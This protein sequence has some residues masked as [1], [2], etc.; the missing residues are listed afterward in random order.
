MNPETGAKTVG[1][2]IEGDSTQKFSA[3][4]GGDAVM[5]LK[6]KDSSMIPDKSY[7][8]LVRS[9]IRAVIVNNDPVSDKVL[10]NHRAGYSGIAS[11]TC[12]KRGE[13]LF[14]PFYA[15][16]NYEHIH[17]GTTQER[18]ILFEPRNAPMTLRRKGEFAAELYQPQI[19]HRSFNS[20]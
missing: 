2:T 20:R 7:I 10:P 4:F 1:G 15:G 18:T 5:Y 3:P 9:G 6:N 12:E 11:L 14:V 8:V 19:L 13:N 17:D 16:I